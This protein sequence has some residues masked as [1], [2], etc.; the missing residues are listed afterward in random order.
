MNLK[1]KQQ[2]TVP[3]R[4]LRS[5]RPPEN[6]STRWYTSRALF[7]VGVGLLFATALVD[8]LQGSTDFFAACAAILLGAGLTQ[9][10]T[11]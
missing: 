2:I 10:E 5:L 7:V 8:P 3:M 1:D 6:A 4:S 11:A 9:L